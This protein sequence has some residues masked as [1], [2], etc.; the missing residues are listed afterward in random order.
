[1][2]AF[3]IEAVSHPISAILAALLV[4]RRGGH[5]AGPAFLGLLLGWG[6]LPLIVMLTRE[7]RPEFA[8][9]GQ[10]FSPSEPEQARSDWDEWRSYYYNLR[11]DLVIQIFL[12]MVVLFYLVFMAA[13][14]LA[15]DLL[16]TVLVTIL[17]SHS[18]A[19]A[20]WALSNL[21]PGVVGLLIV[22]GYWFPWLG[23]VWRYADEVWR[24]SGLV[25]PAEV[26]YR[27][28]GTATLDQ[29]QARL[30]LLDAV[31]RSH[32]LHQLA[33]CIWLL[34]G[35]LFAVAAIQ[36]ILEMRARFS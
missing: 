26:A 3:Q 8:P 30:G 5:W 25:V 1:M 36:A 20:L 31:A 28:P 16:G 15:P 21:W 27:H 24:N 18:V 9:R 2:G 11:Q 10:G 19:C 17:N 13:M 22:S 34:W 35:A 6:S 7:A 4:I 33:L 23:P 12:V 14:W 29:E 32:R